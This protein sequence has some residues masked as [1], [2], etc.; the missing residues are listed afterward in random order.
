MERLAQ[1]I[2]KTCELREKSFNQKTS[3]EATK[4]GKELIDHNK[5]YG[6]SLYEAADKACEL[7]G[8]DTRASHIIYLIIKCSWNESI[9]WAKSYQQ[10]KN[11][12]P[13]YI[14][15]SKENKTLTDKKPPLKE[16]QKKQPN[17]MVNKINKKYSIKHTPTNI[18]LFNDIDPKAIKMLIINLNRLNLKW[19][20]REENIPK[21]FIINCINTLKFVYEFYGI[22]I[23]QKETQPKKIK[24]RK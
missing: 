2:L 20:K 16:T 5:F 18:I 15:G 19:N 11:N 17:F 23:K 21:N 1:A 8:H 12:F 7:L 13:V 9:E 14:P 10:P 3:N 4:G 24:R 22:T 6:L